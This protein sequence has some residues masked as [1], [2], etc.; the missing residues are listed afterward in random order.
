MHSRGGHNY[1]NTAIKPQELNRVLMQY[2]C[3]Q[4]WKIQYGVV[5]V[6]VSVIMNEKAEVSMRSFF[7]FSDLIE[8]AEGN[9]IS[10]KTILTFARL[11]W[12]CSCSP[13]RL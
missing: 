8:A 7:V 3:A 2:I 4:L 12:N 6:R 13:L 1:T 9:V 11:F 5:V 10:F